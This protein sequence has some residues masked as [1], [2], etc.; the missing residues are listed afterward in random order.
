MLVRLGPITSRIGFYCLCAPERKDYCHTGIR[1]LN[2][3]AE[4]CILASPP[5]PPCIRNAGSLPRAVF[6]HVQLPRTP[7][8]MPSH[9]VSPR[10]SSSPMPTRTRLVT[11]PARLHFHSLLSPGYMAVPLSCASRRD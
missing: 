10:Y 5:D 6:P 8:L 3:L 2:E 1:V 4:G 11:G 7:A 9:D